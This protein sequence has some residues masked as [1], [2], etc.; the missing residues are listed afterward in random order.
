MRPEKKY[1]RR[2]ASTTPGSRSRSASG[3]TATR[4]RV[5]AP[6]FT[7]VNFSLTDAAFHQGGPV[8][9]HRRGASIRDTDARLGEVLAAVERAGVFDRTA[10]FLVADHGMEESNP[11]VTG[12][13]GAGARR[14]RH[15]VPRRGLRLPV[16]HVEQAQRAKHRRPGLRPGADETEDGL[17]AR[18]L[19]VAP[20]FM[21]AD[22]HATA[23]YYRDVLG[24][25]LSRYSGD[26]PTFMITRATACS[27]MLK[28]TSEPR[29]AKTSAA[30]GIP[31]CLHLGD[32]R[33]CPGR[34]IAR[35]GGRHRRPARVPAGVPRAGDV[36]VRDCE[37]AHHRLRPAPRL[38][39]P[40]DRP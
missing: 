16:L 38:S 18:M 19:D 2:R 3:A 4:A 12:D 24:F 20:Y 27:I 33:R 30:R 5:P 13:W 6:R 9:R 14:H 21:V 28:E 22:V 8:L 1:R 37:R 25:E 39:L 29:L 36:Q 23:N 26:P 15:P 34:G 7:W 32:Q 35:P 40:P 31:R 17:M 11:A 10:F